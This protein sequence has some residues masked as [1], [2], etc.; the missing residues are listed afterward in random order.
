MIC[1]D[2]ADENRRSDSTNNYNDFL[3]FHLA[4]CDYVRQRLLE[5]IRRF[6]VCVCA[7]NQTRITLK[8]NSRCWNCSERYI[9]TKITSVHER[10]KKARWRERIRVKNRRQFTFNGEWFS[11]GPEIEIKNAEMLLFFS[12]FVCWQP[13]ISHRKQLWNNSKPRIENRLSRGG[14]HKKATRRPRMGSGKA[15]NEKFFLPLLLLLR[16]RREK[17]KKKPANEAKWLA[18]SSFNSL[19]GLGLF[20]SF[21]HG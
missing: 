21:H 10:K 7:R 3:L 1:E 11:G 12:I 19:D 14:L 2:E 5:P 13:P 18:L 16:D 20:S 4:G 6:R 9:R 8:L 15:R 17:T